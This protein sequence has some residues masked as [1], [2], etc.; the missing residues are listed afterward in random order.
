[1]TEAGCMSP[2]TVGP[3]ARSWAFVLSDLEKIAWASLLRLSFLIWK[4][5]MRNFSTGREAM[6]VTWSDKYKMPH[7]HLTHGKHSVILRLF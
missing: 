6:R 2:K 1:M 4:T 5:G 3:G 7:R